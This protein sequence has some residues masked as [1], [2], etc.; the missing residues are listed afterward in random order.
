MKDT[1]QTVFRW[2]NFDTIST[3]LFGSPNAQY[4]STE[5]AYGTFQK[6][7]ADDHICS[8]RLEFY[9]LSND[10]LVTII[11]CVWFQDHQ[12][13]IED[14]DWIRFNFSQSI[15]VDMHLSEDQ[16]VKIIRP[17]WRIINY[18]PDTRVVETIP[19]NKRSA[20]ITVCCK[21]SQI[22]ELTEQHFE[23]LPSLLREELPVSDQQSFHNFHDFTS[24]LNA[25][26]ADVLKTPLKDAMR[27]AY[28]R[29]R[30]IELI[31]LA[32]DH[33][34]HSPVNMQGV[35][36]SENDDRALIEAKELLLA[37]F[38]SAPSISDLSRQL[39]I[40]RNKLFYGFKIKYGCSVSEFLQTQRLEEGKRLLQH[41]DQSISDISHQ[42]GFKHQSNFTTAMKRHF[43]LTPKQFRN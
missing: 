23:N 15:D 3:D 4:S 17:S 43:G 2:D 7:E 38:S 11:D 27:M 36:L 30:A 22:E 21:K 8:G 12:F 24:R 19:A 31:C 16:T 40:N 34:I 18:P 37:N 41:T 5:S 1:S 35:K 28:I 9:E 29:A 14:G 25:I 10:L 33:L 6:I 42:I 32:L 13:I 20:W 26:T 39:G